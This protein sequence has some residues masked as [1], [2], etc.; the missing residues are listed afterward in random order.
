MY[1]E[2]RADDLKRVVRAFSTNQFA[3]IFPRAY[4]SWTGETGRGSAPESVQDVVEY[5]QR[6]FSEYFDVLGVPRNDISAYLLGKTLMEYGP[7]DLPAMALLMYAHGAEKVFCVDRFPLVS[8][9]EKNQEVLRRISSTLP[10]RERERAEQVF[11]QAGEPE[12]GLHSDRVQYLVR[13]N[14]LS[15]LR[16]DADLV[17]SRAVLEH[18][19]DLH[20][21][22]EDM[23][24]ALRAGGVAIHQVD[25]KSH[26]LHRRNS[27]DFLTWP[28]YLWNLMYSQKGVPNRWRVDRYRRWIKECEFDLVQLEPTALA[29]FAEIAEVRPHL[30]AEF[31]AVSDEDLAW[32]GFWMVVKKGTGDHRSSSAASA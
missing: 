29:S 4:V 31:R 11:Q 17:F 2:N 3:R 8:M 27:L 22:F 25:L 14:G 15:G 24:R 16:G 10:P 32:V 6:C 21:T 19:N 18:V 26:G 9:S 7:G 12:S 13:S 5:F 20:G 23:H 1:G 28:T 30:A